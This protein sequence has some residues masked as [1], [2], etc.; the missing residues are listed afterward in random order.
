MEH[1][2]PSSSLNEDNHVHPTKNAQ[3]L[4]SST[5]PRSDPSQQPQSLEEA[6]S[7]VSCKV[8]G[9]SQSQL[10]VRLSQF[11]MKHVAFFFIVA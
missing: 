5:S 6:C 7:A 8:C 9:V 3:V 4:A 11:A 10:R 2:K 1:G